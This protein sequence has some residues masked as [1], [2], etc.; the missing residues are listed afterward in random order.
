MTFKKGN[1]S[2][3]KGIHMSK[4]AKRKSSI[5]HKG[6]KGYWNGKQGARIF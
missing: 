4:E 1:T 3:N 6:K 5:S 2:W